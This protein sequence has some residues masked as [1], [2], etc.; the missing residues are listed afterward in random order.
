[1]GY[2]VQIINVKNK[3]KV[4]NESKMQFNY[5]TTKIH[6]NNYYINKSML[7]GIRFA[8]VST[9]VLVSAILLR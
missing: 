7:Y 8:I 4:L 2:S 5:N 9:V 6:D 3:D 1:M